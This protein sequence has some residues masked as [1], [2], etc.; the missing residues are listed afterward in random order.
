ML[1]PASHEKVRDIPV[2]ISDVVDGRSL[3]ALD[4]NDLLG[5]LGF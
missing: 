2:V 1:I 4:D 5:K 3:K